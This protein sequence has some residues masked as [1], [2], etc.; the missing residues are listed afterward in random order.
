[1]KQLYVTNRNQLREWLSENHAKKAGIWLVF[2]KK[3]TSKP[4][5][6]YEA[7]VEEALC[8]GWI[9]SIIKKIDAAKYV[10]K[11]TPRSD[12]SKWSQLNKKRADKMIRQGRMTEVGL[13]KIKTAKKTGLWDKDPRPQISFD[14]PPE[15]A[16]ALARNKKAEENF[17]KL[18]P[19]YRKH[20]IGWI[21]FAKRPETKKRRIEESIALLENGKK[22]GLK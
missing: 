21:T 10:R 5:I 11:F 3:E 20:Y 17:D 4:T 1:M 19:S 13:A 16:K 9:D 14:I 22:L 7:A 2:Y 6:E 15:F 18:A 12:K 8:F